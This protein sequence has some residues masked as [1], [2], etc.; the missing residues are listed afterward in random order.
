MSNKRFVLYLI[1]WLLV[2]AFAVSGF[3]CLL[4][5]SWA[6]LPSPQERALQETEF[7]LKEFIEN[8]T[9][10]SPTNLTSMIEQCGEFL[11][12]AMV[13]N[14]KQY[15]L[16]VAGVFGAYGTPTGHGATEIIVDV[17]FPDGVQAQI[18]YYNYTLES[19]TSVP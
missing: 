18:Y 19:C 4:F 13:S 14:N 12:K 6:N 5:M 1:F 8:S 7:V 15:T 16:R 11:R 9:V 3:F 10:A 17:I 2:V